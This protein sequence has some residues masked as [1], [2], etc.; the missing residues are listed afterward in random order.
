MSSTSPDKSTLYYRKITR[1]DSDEVCLD[2]DMIRL[3]IAV[4]ENKSM[5]RIAAEVGMDE[6]T[7]EFTLSKLLDLHLI[8]A[9]NRD[10]Y[11]LDQRFFDLLRGNLSKVVGPMAQ[12]LIEDTVLEMGFTLR[13][14]PQNQAAEL[15]S[16]VS[17]EI[18]DEEG[19]IQFKKAMLGL[20]R[21]Q[22]V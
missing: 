22:G 9:V 18:P 7:L 13:E 10:A 20:I 21:K 3:L 11:L 4:D 16:A 17:T 12:I 19:R 2:A 5:D 8:E 6:D 15:V 14:V 1:M